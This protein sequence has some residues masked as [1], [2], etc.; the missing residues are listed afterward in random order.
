MASNCVSI[1]IFAEDFQSVRIA[2]AEMRSVM[3]NFGC[4]DE[5]V[6]KCELCAVEAMNNVVEHAYAGRLPARFSFQISRFGDTI[7][8]AVSDTGRPLPEGVLAGT[9]LPQSDDEP[10]EGGYGLA[11]IRELM[12]DVHYQRK[13]GV[14]TLTMSTSITKSSP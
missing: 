4:S 7:E 6:A 10:R 2:A 5:L 9:R 1:S 13:S 3:A 12:S 11:L 8:L 14:N